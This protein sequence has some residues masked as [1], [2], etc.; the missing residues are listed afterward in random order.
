MIQK[1]LTLISIFVF[2]GLCELLFQ[3]QV[4]LEEEY[5]QKHTSKAISITDKKLADGF[6][7]LKSKNVFYENNNKISNC[8]NFVA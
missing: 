1:T 4:R 6:N 5:W 7:S 8:N 3:V 2:A